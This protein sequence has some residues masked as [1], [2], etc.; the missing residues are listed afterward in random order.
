MGMKVRLEKGFYKGSP[1]PYGY[2]YNLE[3]GHLDINKIESNAVKEIFNKYLELGTLNQVRN[4]CISRGFPT[5]RGAKWGLNTI[6]R[7]LSNRVYLGYYMYNDIQTHH[8][9]V[10]IID[11]DLFD[12]VQGMLNERTKYRV[13]NREFRD[14]DKKNISYDYKG[15][16]K[17]IYVE[18]KLT[19]K[20]TDDK[21]RQLLQWLQLNPEKPF[22]LIV[23]SPTLKEDI[24]K[25]IN[26]HAEKKDYELNILKNLHLINVSNPYAFCAINGID[27][28]MGD[29]QNLAKFLDDFSFWFDFF[30]DFTV[31]RIRN[32]HHSWFSYPS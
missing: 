23:F 8:K 4:Y 20:F 31:S 24:L 3:T 26:I 7:I 10:Q 25:E 28:V 29:S 17:R 11:N 27:K 18:I 13:K 5:K 32:G 30:G 9:D 2:D 1:P 19:K 14:I 6:R 21:A 16:E 22:I 12:R 15:F